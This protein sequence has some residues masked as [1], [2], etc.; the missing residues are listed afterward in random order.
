MCKRGLLG[1]VD[2]DGNCQLEACN[3]LCTI[4]DS[5]HLT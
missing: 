4:Q 1:T 2:R 5:R 3:G